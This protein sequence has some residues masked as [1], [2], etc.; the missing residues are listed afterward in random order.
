MCRNEFKR[1][2]AG[3]GNW[4]IQT[5]E[6]AQLVLVACFNLHMILGHLYCVKYA[7]SVLLNLQF[8]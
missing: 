1:E 6:I 5:D 4:G 2:G 8:F 7:L 3:R